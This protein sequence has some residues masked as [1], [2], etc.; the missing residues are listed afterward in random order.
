MSLR[1]KGANNC[2]K[3]FRCIESEKNCAKYTFICL[4]RPLLVKLSQTPLP[5][6][7]TA[8]AATGPIT[9]GEVVRRHR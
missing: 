2:A 3:K 7:P 5:I 1:K 6:Q 4:P 9:V 8:A